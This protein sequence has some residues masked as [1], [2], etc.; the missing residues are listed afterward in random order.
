MQCDEIV[1][2][3]FANSGPILRYRVA[4]ELMDVPAQE[5]TRLLGAS[6]ATPEVQR[7]LANLR[8]SRSIH[9]STDTHAENALSKLLDYGLDCSIP[10][11]ARSAEHLLDFP[12]SQW[13]PFVLLP[14][15]VRAGYTGKP[16]VMELLTSRLEK[17]HPTARLGSFDFYLS[18]EEASRV[19]KAWRGKPIYRDEFGHQAGYPLPTCYDFYALA[20][21][22]SMPG[23]VDFPAISESMPGIVDFPA[24]SESM[25][26]IVDFPAISESM[27]SIVDFP[28]ISESMP[29][30]VDFPAISES[31]VAFLSDARFQSTVGG[32]GWDKAGRRCYAAGRV[33]LACVTPARLVL[34][35]ELGARF[36]AARQSAWF[37]QGL[38]SLEQYRTPRGTY[39]FPPGLLA[40][41]T[42]YQLYGG[43]HM[44]LGEDRRSPLA[45]ELESTFHMLYIHKRM[46]NE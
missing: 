18:A 45:L 20:Y 17:L 26:G 6:L 46:Q 31:I 44:G 7:W 22:P 1:E 12:L 11:F 43:S 27:P 25:P 40:E 30:I 8:A 28:A 10:A 41:K 35:L 33:F 14:F 2:W 15:L 16:R 39:R 38:S 37:Q 23:M 3:L 24:I 34:F 29:G 32:Y 21:C 19:P 42:G 5:R 4:V 9:G 36:N 13:D